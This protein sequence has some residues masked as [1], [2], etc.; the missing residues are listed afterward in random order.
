MPLKHVT[1]RAGMCTWA[2]RGWP[3]Q[4]RPV[5][6]VPKTVWS[7]AVL[8]RWTSSTGFS[9]FFGVV[10]LHV[11]IDMNRFWGGHLTICCFSSIRS[12]QRPIKQPL[13]NRNTVCDMCGVKTKHAE[14]VTWGKMQRPPR[15]ASLLNFNTSLW[16]RKTMFAL[17]CFQ[18]EG[19]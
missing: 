6:D 15:W 7:F 14:K 19:L 13:W 3:R 16:G 2:T 12:L 17:S 9:G 5:L 11:R 18:F 1:S 8:D 10:V 4:C